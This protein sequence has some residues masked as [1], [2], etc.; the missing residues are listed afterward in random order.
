[1]IALLRHGTPGPVNLGNPAEISM[2]DLAALIC[3][4]THSPSEIT[5]RPLPPDDPTRR[6][7]ETSLAAQLLN[8]TPQVGLRDGLN[9]TIDW[10]RRNYLGPE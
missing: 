6:C 2:L 3:H 8:W 1:M 9:P 7:P 10:F 4:L 5:F